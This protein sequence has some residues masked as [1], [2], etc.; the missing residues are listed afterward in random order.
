MNTLKYANRAK[1]LACRISPS[2]VD[3]IARKVQQ[4]HSEEVGY[5]T[6]FFSHFLYGTIRFC[7]NRVLRIRW[8]MSWNK[9]NWRQ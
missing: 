9:L 4:Q 3:V 7:F 1:E 6:C 2:V 8:L 5:D